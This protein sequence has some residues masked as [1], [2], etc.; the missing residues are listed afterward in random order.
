MFFVMF[1]MA[2]FRGS[3]DG[4]YYNYL[5]FA[6]DIGRDFSKVLNFSYP[7]EFSFRLASFFINLLGLSR[8]WV[9]ILMNFLSLAPTAYVVYKKSRLPFLSSLIFIPVFLQ[10]DM[11]TSRTA[12][13]IGLGLLAM[14]LWDISK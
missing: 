13:S 5:W 2:A 12:T 6:K 11:Q 8:Q 4:D 14:Y 1:L 9:I 3:G 7:V 10:F